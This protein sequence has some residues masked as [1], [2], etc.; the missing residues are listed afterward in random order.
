MFPP[1]MWLL[2][3]H[4]HNDIDP[5]ISPPLIETSLQ[6]GL[7]NNRKQK[8]LIGINLSGDLQ[9]ESFTSRFVP[10]IY[11]SLFSNLYLQ[12]PVTYKDQ[13]KSFAS[14]S[15]ATS[16]FPGCT[17]YLQ[18]LAITLV[19]QESKCKVL[20]CWLV[21]FLQ[22]ERDLL[23]GRLDWWDSFKSLWKNWLLTETH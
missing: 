13:T 14:Q 10:V 12:L 16:M 19:V 6:S 4:R 18:T 23:Y 3:V 20:L 21:C 2:Q 1:T 17:L 9:P 8:K 15:M 11:I 22:P 5:T 7:N